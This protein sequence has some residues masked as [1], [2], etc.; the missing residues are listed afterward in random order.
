MTTHLSTPRSLRKNRSWAVVE[1]AAAGLIVW[2]VAYVVH[3]DQ[4]VRSGSSV[5]T[6]GVSSVLV[7]SVLAGLAAWASAALFDRLGRSRREWRVMAC[8]VQALSLLGPL[9]LAI[10]V[11]STL[12]LIALH[13]TVG[14]ILITQLGRAESER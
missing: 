3:G 12:C 1:A 4:T 7:A 6:I 14:S 13:L 5:Q 8:A 11:G 9:S 10:G 2:C